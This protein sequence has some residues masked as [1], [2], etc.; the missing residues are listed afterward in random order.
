MI[1][2]L[3][4]P[5]R[6]SRVVFLIVQRS[7]AAILPLVLLLTACGTTPTPTPP[8]KIIS[9]PEDMFARGFFPG[10]TYLDTKKEDTDSDGQPEWVVFYR[11]DETG[12]KG[13]VAALIYDI[14]VD[15]ESQLPIA[16][17]YKLRTPDQNYLAQSIPQLSLVDIVREEGK[18]RKEL[19]FST[20]TELVFFRLTRD[21]SSPP[22][23]N[24]PLYRCIGFFRS[25]GGVR[26]NPE[27]LQVTVTSR[28]GYERSQ[29]VTRREYKPGTWPEADGYFLA[30]TT[31][32]VSPFESRVDFPEGIPATILD[33]PYP[34]KIVLAFYQ[35]LGKSDAKPT[36][37][38]YLSTQAATELTQ[39][40]LRYGLPFPINQVE[41]AIVQELSYYPTQEDSTSALVI[42]KVIFQPK[43]G[44]PSSLIE[45]RWRL[46]R[47]GTQWK[48]DYAEPG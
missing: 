48:M 15:P 46:I 37:Y 18:P 41:R 34:E 17:P 16:Y 30:N 42:A 23:D 40:K 35:T 28:A 13:P 45:V 26:F 21:P 36:I 9:F 11:F 8:A 29:L 27:N 19:V 3:N 33:T 32:L 12:E 39:G 38:E 25:D 47:V 24:P 10:K 6:W 7:C 20:D 14:V 43:G 5:S 44:T 22:V 2:G 31:T 4:H 1:K